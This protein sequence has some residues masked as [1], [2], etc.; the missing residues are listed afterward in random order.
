[1]TRV[2]NVN[3]HRRGQHVD[4]HC[5]N[6]AQLVQLLKHQLDSDLDNNSTP[7]QFGG[8]YGVL[9]KITCATYG[10]TIVGKGTTSSLWEEVSRE[11]EVYEVLKSARCSSP[12]ISRKN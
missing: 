3:L 7:M 8:S 10:Y 9:F 5:V 12:G 11:A 6:A 2:L 4:R 1:M